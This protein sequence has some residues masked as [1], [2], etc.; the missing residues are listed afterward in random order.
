MLNGF[1]LLISKFTDNII[2]VR[3]A[4]GW[5]FSR[6]AEIHCEIFNDPNIFQSLMMTIGQN[7]SDKPKISSHMC[8]ILELMSGFFSSQQNP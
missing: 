2:K 3:E 5:V 8:K 6:I 4:I 7:I 1:N